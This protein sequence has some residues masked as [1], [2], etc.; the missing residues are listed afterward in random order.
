VKGSGID[1]C[2]QAATRIVAEIT[3]T[4]LPNKVSGRDAK[5]DERPD[6]EGIADCMA[7]PFALVALG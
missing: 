6:W 4:T 5:R 1:T 3:M 2:A 7:V